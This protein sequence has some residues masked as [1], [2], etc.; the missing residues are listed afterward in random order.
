MIPSIKE[1]NPY[2]PDRPGVDEAL[3]PVDFNLG[4]RYLRDFEIAVL[5]NKM[6]KKKLFVTIVLDCCHSGGA[7]RNLTTE[8]TIRKIAGVDEHGIDWVQLSTDKSVI[9]Q[10]EI[11]SI[12]MPGFW[13]RA[14]TAKDPWLTRY[15]HTL[16]AACLPHQL[17]NEYFLEYDEQHHQVTRRDSTANGKRHGLLTYFLITNLLD[18][19]GKLTHLALCRRVSEIIQN[20]T[21]ERGLS[22]QVPLLMGNSGSLLFLDEIIDFD[23]GIPIK[24]VG[25]TNVVLRAGSAEGVCEGDI[26]GIYGWEVSNY[27]DPSLLLAT[28]RVTGVRG[29]E[30]DATFDPGHRSSEIQIGSSARLT[31]RGIPQLQVYLQL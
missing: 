19:P 1:S 21:D 24:W 6:A 25:P 31:E 18:A 20:F 17:A 4:G 27:N 15:G 28:A 11:E 2:R 14:Q 26:Y 16:I 29:L 8:A 7:T 30:S 10:G 12:M 13:L 5:L 3:I 22:S 9:S 23:Y